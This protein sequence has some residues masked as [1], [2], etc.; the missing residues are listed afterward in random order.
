MTNFE[1]NQIQI[2]R[3][4]LKEFPQFMVVVAGPRQV[5]KS[6]MVRQALRHLRGHFVSTDQPVDF[7]DATVMSVSSATPGAKPTGEWLV[8]QWTRA[9]A[10]AMALQEGELYVL[11]IDEIQKIP[12]WSEIVK[13]LWDDDRAGRIPLHIVL[14]GSSP[15]LMQKGLTESLAGRYETIPLSHWSYSEMQDAFDFSLEEFIYFGG[16]PGSAPLIRDENRWRNYV[17][18]SL[19]RPNIEKDILLM[20]RVDKP[21]LLKQLFDL[22]CGAYSGQIISLTKILGQLQDAGNTVTLTDYLHLLSQAGLLTGLQKYAG[23][24]HRRR[25]SPPKMN[26]HNT[27]LMSAIGNYSFSESR[28]DRSYWGRLVESTVGAFLINNS[29]D[30]Y[31]VFY[32]RESPHEVDFIVTAGNKMLAIEVKTGSKPAQRTGLDVF[33]K[34][35]PQTIPLIVGEGGIPIR[36]FL[37]RPIQSWL[38]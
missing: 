18:G 19:I 25:A 34:K 17:R 26:A 13:G 21:A 10:K 23:H 2:L 27:A 20:T 35:Y 11:A 4:R 1:R 6:F 9:R 3:Q 29:P 16:Y 32:W 38:G 30:D 37:I 7:A 15:W 36:E 28:Q 22:G 14:L 5:G 8:T 31:G 24:E 12:R 33:C